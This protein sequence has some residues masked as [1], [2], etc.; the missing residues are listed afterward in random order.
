MFDSFSWWIIDWLIDCRTDRLIVPLFDW[1]IDWLFFW[2]LIYWFIRSFKAKHLL[3]SYILFPF[4]FGMYNN[5]GQW[6]SRRRKITKQ[7]TGLPI[8]ISSFV[9]VAWWQWWW[10][11]QWWRWWR[12]YVPS[13]IRNSS[14]DVRK[15]A[16]SPSE[17]DER[18][19]W[20][21]SV[22]DRSIFRQ[23]AQHGL[24]RKWRRRI[25][26]P[27]RYVWLSRSQVM[28]FSTDFLWIFVQ[29]CPYK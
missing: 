4:Q 16:V 6:V 13:A 21:W 10:W 26:R 12:W 9:V 2:R 20:I 27:G 5:P 7:W 8:L 28:S 18:R 15:Q 22:I 11:W 25:S 17:H 14:P 3:F 24:S 1:L 29:F 23:R 19:R